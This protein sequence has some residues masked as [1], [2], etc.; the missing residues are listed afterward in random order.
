MRVMNDLRARDPFAG[1]GSQRGGWHLWHWIARAACLIVCHAMAFSTEAMQTR[2]CDDPR[3]F[4]HSPVNV[5]LLPYTYTGTQAQMAR[6][7]SEAAGRLG[8]LME[9]DSL[10]E[11]TKYQA[12]GVENLVS[13]PGAEPCDA[14]LIWDRLVGPRRD[15][16]AGVRP[17]GAVAMIW[18]RIYEEGT[19]LYVQS[20]L[21]FGRAEMSERIE[22]TVATSYARATF[23]A[24]LPTQV[25]TLPPRRITMDDIASINQEFSRLAVVR[26][27]PSETAKV[28]SRLPDVGT[29]THSLQPFGYAVEEVRGDWVRVVSLYGG[30]PGWIARVGSKAWPLRDRLPDLD[31]LDAVVGYLHLRV[32]REAS[33]FAKPA[34][35]SRLIDFSRQS[36][37]RYRESTK[38]ASP[39][40]DALGHALLGTMIL[41]GSASSSAPQEAFAEFSQSVR[42]VPY[43]AEARNLANVASVLRCCSG[44]PRSEAGAQSTMNSLL[45]AISVDPE[46]RTAI[47]NLAAFH[48]LLNGWP[49]AVAV[50]GTT[51]IERQR[52]ALKQLSGAR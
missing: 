7:L 2:R 51:G 37:A 3:V 21:R 38:G 13:V 11:M 20:Y 35:A 44:R 28:I 32:A 19:T 52:D 22:R 18:G 16:Q 6:P 30:P 15:R 39:A 36:F 27:A 9:H 31:F 26:D 41:L 29:P 46:N 43:N 25:V 4:A 34:E 24:Q 33:G 50:I 40:A 47:D 1:N 42:L 49:E 10:V 12:I 23:A 5:L 45:D 14:E 48:L 17:G 8:L